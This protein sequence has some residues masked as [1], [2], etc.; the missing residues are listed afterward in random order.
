MTAESHDKRSPDRRILDEIGRLIAALPPA[1]IGWVRAA[2]ELP[3]A[4]RA[5]AGILTRA[6]ADAAAR[7]RAPSGVRGRGV[8]PARALG[9]RSGAGRGRHRADPGRPRGAARTVPVR[10]TRTLW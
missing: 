9:S 5:I 3:A 7:R 6:V 4:R 2:Q 8:P 10:L 1:P